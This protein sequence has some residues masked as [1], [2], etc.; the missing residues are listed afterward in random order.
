[1]IRAGFAAQS[2]STANRKSLDGQPVHQGFSILVK[3]K[4][5]DGTNGNN[6]TNGK[7]FGKECYRVEVV[8]S[9]HLNFPFVPLF[10]FV[11]SF[12]FC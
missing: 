8:A 4:R 2:I 12:L 10:P 6:G 9:S 5:N 3:K 1:M 7:E 11:S